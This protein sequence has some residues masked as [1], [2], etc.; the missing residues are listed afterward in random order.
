MNQFHAL[1]MFLLK[2]HFNNIFPCK[3]RSPSG[4]LL[5]LSDQNH[6]CTSLVTNICRKSHPTN[7]RLR[8]MN[9]PQCIIF[10]SLLIPPPSYAQYLPWQSIRWHPLTV[11]GLTLNLPTTT[12]VAPPLNVIKWQMGF[13]SV[14]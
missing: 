12:I 3:P 4:S 5:R 2:I 14:A 11:F 13:N 7:H 9:F 1:N 8:H 6:V 10:S